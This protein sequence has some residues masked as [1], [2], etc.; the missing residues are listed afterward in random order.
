MTQGLDDIRRQI[1]A[2]DDELRGLL[3]A[4]RDLV[5]QIAAAK[6]ASGA[7][8]PLRPARETQQMRALADYATGHGLPVAPLIAIW[9]QIIS[10]AIAQQGGLKII[11]TAQTEALAQAHFGAALPVDTQPDMAALA[12]DALAVLPLAAAAQHAGQV[13][14]LLPVLGPPQAVLVGAVTEEPLAAPVTLV[15]SSAPLA[16]GQPLGDGLTLLDGDVDAPQGATRLG[17]FDAP[18]TTEDAS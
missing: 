11:A 3:R 15:H 18:L 17:V 12:A 10:M 1:D 4:R 8:M 16:D 5:G 14:G 13:V 7:G 2:L 6:Q 9:R